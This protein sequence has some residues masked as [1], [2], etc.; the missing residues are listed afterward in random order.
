MLDADRIIFRKG[1]VRLL[2]DLD[3]ASPPFGNELLCIG[4]YAGLVLVG[5]AQRG[6]FL[7]ADEL[8]AVV[9]VVTAA[10]DSGVARLEVPHDLSE[11]AEFEVSPVR[12][13]NGASFRRARHQSP[14]CVRHPIEIERRVRQ[15]KPLGAA[16]LVRKDKSESR[17]KGLLLCR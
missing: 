7:L 9:G 15:G 8:I 14:P 12:P 17:L 2:R 4:R 5:Q 10:F 1:A 3:E 16:A 13:F 11:D 6:G